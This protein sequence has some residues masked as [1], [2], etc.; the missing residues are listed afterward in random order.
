MIPNDQY[1]IVVINLLIFFGLVGLFKPGW[2][3]HL[4]N[5]P[6]S[7]DPRNR[8]DTTEEDR[9]R[10]RIWGVMSLVGALILAVLAFA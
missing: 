7:L 8:Q 4:S 9:R 6:Y 10:A 1:T 5:L 2:F 3:R